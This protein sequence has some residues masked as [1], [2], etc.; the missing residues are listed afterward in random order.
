MGTL[1]KYDLSSC[2]CVYFFETGTGLG[3]SLRH[4]IHNGRFTKLFSTEIHKETALK[5]QALFQSK[6]AVEIRNE[7]STIAL[8]KILLSLDPLEPILFFLDAHFPGEVS[9]NYSYDK[10]IHNDI[11]MPLKEEL[12]IIKALRATSPDIL[13]VDDLNLYEDGPFENGNIV[14]SY[15]NIKGEERD[16]SFIDKIFEDKDI[17]R[18]YRDEGYLILKPSGSTFCLRK[19]PAFY[20]LKRSMIK[21]VNK[22]LGAQ[23]EER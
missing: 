7:N 19:L 12:K 10:N 5:A 22:Y 13:I 11:T 23:L 16:L 20:R 9:E 1:R 2:G 14:K 4:A 21:N 8:K 6:P 15:A 3:A 18:D 17:S